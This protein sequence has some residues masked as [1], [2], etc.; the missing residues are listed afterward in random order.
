MN[1]SIAVYIIAGS[2]N[3]LLI[4]ILIYRVAVEK[5]KRQLQIIHQYINNM[6]AYNSP[7]KLKQY[8]DALERLM[9]QSG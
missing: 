4:N 6:R 1:D 5:K 7:Q 3:L 2:I 8:E 9:R